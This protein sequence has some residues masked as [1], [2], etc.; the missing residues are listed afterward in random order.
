MIRAALRSP[1]TVLV[2][3]IAA[4]AFGVLSIRR[5]PIDILPKLST[6]TV[7]VAQPYGGLSPAQMEGYVTSYY[8]YH[9]LYVTGVKFV[10]SK[11]IQGVALIKLQFHDG[12]NMDQA[13]AEVVGYVNRARAFMPP[14]TVPPFII[15]YD[16]GSA[17][18]GQLV[19]QSPVRPLGEIQD[20][21]LFRVRPMFAALPG[22]SAPPPFGGNQRT[23][24]VRVDPTRLRSYGL[25]PDAVVQAVA[26]GNTITPAG[27]VRDDSLTMLTSS[28]AV[29]SNIGD[30]AKIPLRTASGGV[31]A[32]VYVGDVATVENGTDVPTGY[33]LIN[34][35]RSVYIPVTKRAD[36]S[37]WDVVH[38][39][40][41][42]LPSMQ[43][44][45][46]DDIHVSFEFDQSAYVVAA[47]R[48]LVTEGA[49]GALLTGLV[50]LLFLGD[51][52]SALIVVVTIPVALLAAAVGL[53]LAGQTI[54]VM[55]LSGLALAVGVLVDEATVT[56]ENIHRHQESGQPIG[57][58]VYDAAREIARPKLLILLSLLAV[59]APALF[60]TG[61]PRAMFLPLSMSVGFAMIASY[62]LSQTVVPVFANWFLA[63]EPVHAGRF[64]RLVARGQVWFRARLARLS[65]RRRPVLIGYAVAA[66]L[67]IG[68]A[69]RFIGSAILPPVDSG[70]FQLRLRAP[71]GTRL[72]RMEERVR[73]ALAL[74]DETAGPGNVAITSTFVGTQPPSY[75]IN[76]VYLW[77]SGPQEA[78][79]LVRMAPTARISL[80]AFR[81]Q[82]RAAFHQ[83]MPDLSLSFE[84]GDLVDQVMSEGATTPVEVI[85][86]GRDL[87]QSRAYGDK[88]RHALEPLSF[89]R[90]VG[91][92]Q[93]L[94]YP[95]IAVDVDRAR[96]G[97]LGV[98]VAEVGRSLV[99][100]TSSSRFTEPNYWLD[101]TTGTAYQVQ[102]EVPQA[103]MS[104]IGTVERIPVQTVRASDREGGGDAPLFVGDLAT[105]SRVATVGEYDRLN[106]QRM[107]TLTANLH[108][109][110][111]G[112]ARDGVRRAIAAAGTLP[113]GTTVTVRGQ[114]DL[115]DQMFG[116]LRGGL[117]LALFVILLL[118][119][120]T[121]QSF[122]L[123]LTVLST[124]PAVAAGALLLLVVTGT[125]LNI[126]SF[127][128][129]IMAL[130]IS[131]ANAIL[132]V[133]AAESART[134]P[135][136]LH[137]D[138][139][140]AGLHAAE[141]RLRPILMT[142]CA[143]TA[144]MIPMALGLGEGGAQTAP[145]GIAVIGGLLASTLAA[146]VALPLIYGLVQR[147]AGTGSRSLDPDDPNG[148]YAHA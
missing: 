35:K 131:A 104:N 51:R 71:T 123:A 18:V 62:L 145:L 98:S 81:E 107:L 37:T 141:L 58:A 73:A 97:L 12:T 147:S 142:T 87:A 72:E 82:L 102:V 24:L 33:A 22:V 28:N 40:K 38:Q 121:F 90:D 32:A 5:L 61:T 137:G 44:A 43:S 106:Q 10:E 94:D 112:R 21:A 70:Q 36:A 60:M 93:S 134:A 77:T 114:I 139:R 47:L 144:G 55:T 115:L 45:L 79:L 26:R 48:N 17:P 67:V 39:V 46:P 19:F 53:S 84:P 74:I 105:L 7:Y 2:I 108:G 124:A 119:A 80:E 4:V 120:A 92:A 27:N 57:R 136:P 148:V 138:A 63:R 34:G 1:V 8:E 49:L 86:T 9:F 65:D 52:R 117:V 54:N 140:G 116:E 75:P 68:L 20:L 6:P 50:V 101:S 59:F 23:V 42:A 14:G 76:T 95:T 111:L 83:Q 30:L 85:I 110:D 16:A 99:A 143:M 56:I 109:A 66:L 96:A 3:V 69:S 11:S 88:L 133:T 125:T 128:G 100:A 89:L 64:A 132:L 103:L 126:Q 13:M 127:L 130:G 113:K 129:L 118:L 15:R 29:V 31:T 25:S 41:A 122:R 146:L 78:V 135:G 91:Y